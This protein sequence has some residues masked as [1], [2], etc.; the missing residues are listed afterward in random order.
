M[1]KWLYLHHGCP[2]E[3]SVVKKMEFRM[4]RGNKKTTDNF[5]IAQRCG[6]LQYVLEKI[7]LVANTLC[8]HKLYKVQCLRLT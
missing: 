3:N 8:V 6:I 1:F 5:L 7:A 4:L 2:L